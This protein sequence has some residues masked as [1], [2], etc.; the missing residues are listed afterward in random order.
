MTAVAHDDALLLPVKLDISIM[1][2]CL[3]GHRIIVKKALNGFCVPEVRD[4]DFSSILDINV[5]IENSIRLH[6][7]IGALLAKTVATGKV[8][9]GSR[10]TLLYQ[11]R[12]Q[13]F[14]DSVAAP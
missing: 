3:T 14:I 1:R 9:F 6:H 13:G 10:H 2:H 8:N 5:G 7:D 4:D 12:P 11:F